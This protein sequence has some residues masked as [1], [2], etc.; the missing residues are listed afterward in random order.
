MPIQSTLNN[1]TTEWSRL[2]PNS[3][4]ALNNT[5]S[6]DLGSFFL[7][8]KSIAGHT[9]IGVAVIIAPNHMFARDRQLIKA[10]TCILSHMDVILYYFIWCNAIINNYITS[11][12][13]CHVCT[14][15]GWPCKVQVQQLQSTVCWPRSESWDKYCLLLLV[16]HG[17]DAT[18]PYCISSIT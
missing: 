1:E 3:L 7:R 18:A 5:N 4:T 10:W 13:L 16:G 12:S 15:C 9:I 8:L 6:I 14:A 2:S 17:H 11:L